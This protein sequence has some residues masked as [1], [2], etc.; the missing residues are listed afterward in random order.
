VW[1]KAYT[2]TFWRRPLTAATDAISEAGFLI[3]RLVEARPNPE[4]EMRDPSA[5]QELTTRPFFM[6]LRLRP[7]Q[8]D[9]SVA[10]F[11]GHFFVIQDGM[12]VSPT[13][14]L[15]GISSAVLVTRST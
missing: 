15:G 6:H 8:P 7:A 11:W 1:V 5:F 12:R 13:V 14:R 2:V 4:L 10:A 3:D 9:G